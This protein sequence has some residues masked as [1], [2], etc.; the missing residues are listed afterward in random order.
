MFALSRNCARLNPIISSSRNSR[1]FCSRE[2]IVSTSIL[3]DQ[4]PQP[5]SGPPPAAESPKSS[6]SFLKFG[7]IAALTG[8]IATSAYASYGWYLSFASNCQFLF[9]FPRMFWSYFAVLHLIWFFLIRGGLCTWIVL[10]WCVDYMK[11]LTADVSKYRMVLLIAGIFV[12]LSMVSFQE[13]S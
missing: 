7:L 8:G 11:N 1:R 4:T 6:W 5:P 13:A 3:T 9:E 12:H 10:C 2:S